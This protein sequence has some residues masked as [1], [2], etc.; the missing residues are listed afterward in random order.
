MSTGSA[1]RLSRGILLL[2]ATT[3][4]LLFA[5]NSRQRHRS[6]P[7]RAQ[8]PRPTLQTDELSEHL[9]AAQTYQIAEAWPAAE[10]ENRAAAALALERLGNLESLQGAPEKATKDLQD[11]IALKDDPSARTDLAIIFMRQQKIEP[12]LAQITE[13][14]KANEKDFR[15]QHVAGKLEYMAGH[16]AEAVAHLEKSVALKADPEAAYTLGMAY[17][18]DKNK[19]RASL[20]F[21]EMLAA[22]SDKATAHVLFGRAYRDAGY[23]EPA[24]KELESAIA[25]DPETPR[26]HFYLGL[27]YLLEHDMAAFPLARKQFAEEARRHPQ[28]F[29]SHYFLG[30]MSAMEKDNA[31]A[32]PE[33]L[34]ATALNPRSPDAWLYLGQAQLDSGDLVAAE[35]SL[36]SAVRTT[37]DISRNAFQVQRAHFMLSRIYSRT[38]RKADS[39]KELTIAAQ[40]KKLSLAEAR[41][42]I[43]DI[44]DPKVESSDAVRAIAERSAHSDPELNSSDDLAHPPVLPEAE[45]ASI[46]SARRQLQATL[47]D[48]Y[49]NLGV[50]AVKRGETS[51]ALEH[52]A[53]AAQWNPAL[54]GVNRNLGIMAFRAQDYA[55]AVP[56]LEVASKAAPEDALIRRMLGMSYYI[57]NDFA[58]AAQTLHPIAE[59][60]YDDPTVI[61][62]YGDSLA[63]SQRLQE[64]RAV[65]TRIAEAAP[66]DA[67][68]QFS[69][70]QGFSAADDYGRALD[71]FRK[72][73]ALQ[74][75]YPKAHYSAGQCLIRLNRLPEAEA[76]FRKEL[77]RDPVDP[78][79]RYHLAYVLM[80]T[81]QKD[82]AR[83]LLEALVQEQ[84]TYGD[85]QY[86]LGK[87]LLDNGDLKNSIPH[88]ESAAATQP[89]RE[90]PHYQLS[91][92][93]RRDGRTGEAD[94]EL[95]LYQQMK[96]A[97]RNR[98]IRGMEPQVSVGPGDQ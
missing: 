42:V 60:L 59:Q 31:A 26:A 64:A 68:A 52:F 90:Y 16:Y 34:K 28:D 7:A 76:E 88:L 39:E 17:L 46:Q 41:E 43:A 48:C 67:D 24:V 27:T 25:V 84:P 72:V 33:L 19:E 87:L 97:Q 55:R 23:F 29:Y 94:R 38:N 78:Q 18:R 93:Y 45:Q 85:A 14:L 35:K 44:I 92:A 13:A 66:A 37:S 81:Q 12:A 36:S 22:A 70:A 8:M 32:I 40:Q 95:K 2:V 79:S 57:Q 63:K 98:P 74:P 80:E 82:Q 51:T 89:E 6:V 69:A 73:S 54:P 10:K 65:F 96:A 53:T 20:L 5:Q 86:Q 4:G 9:K 50:I 49:N 91:I 58:K 62:A 77:Q 61:S 11:S 75:A 47:A 15:A 1:Q 56:A 83:A 21:E 30:M 3:S 71:L